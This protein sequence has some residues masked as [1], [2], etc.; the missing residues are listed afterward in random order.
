MKI[1]I[2]RHGDAVA[3][4]RT[5]ALHSADAARQLS[6]KGQREVASSI[7][8]LA[9]SYGGVIDLAIASPLIRA[10]QTLDLAAAHLS[11]EQ[12]ETSAEITPE[13]DAEL[14]ASGLLARLQI[15]PAE[16]VLVVS[17]MPFVS[18]LVEYL[19]RAGQ[20]LSFPTAG[21]VVLDIE[22]LAMSGKVLGKVTAEDSGHF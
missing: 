11:I 10:Q 3:P 8:T 7:A 13:A 18:L 19:D 21:I 9:A 17:H 1:F 6:T 5:S 16:S 20:V 2:M 12:R 14:F 22:P 15:E 4:P